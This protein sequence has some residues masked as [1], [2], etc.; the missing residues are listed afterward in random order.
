MN[1]RRVAAMALIAM[2]LLACMIICAI[3]FRIGFRSGVSHAIADSIY[4]IV[5]DDP[6]IDPLGNSYDLKL[7]IDLDGDGY[8]QG[9]YIC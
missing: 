2:A 1:R 4:Y 3:G 8:E 6:Y 9:M 7:H 5:D